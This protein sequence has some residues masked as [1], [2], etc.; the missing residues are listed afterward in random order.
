MK[1]II[2]T[3]IFYVYIHTWENTNYVYIGKGKGLRLN[4]NNRNFFWK[5]IVAKYG[6]PKREIIKNSMSEK[7]AFLFEIE[8]ISKYKKYM[9]VVNMTNGGEG[10]SGLKHSEESRKKIKLSLHNRCC[11]QETREKLRIL[12]TNRVVTQDTRDK[13]SHI[14]AD[15][16]IY[17]FYINGISQEGTTRE[18]AKKYNVSLSRL[19]NLVAGRIKSHMGITFKKELANYTHTDNK[20]YNFMHISGTEENC[21]KEELYKK[22]NLSRNALNAITNSNIRTKTHKGWYLKGINPINKTLDS[23]IY[24]FY[25]KKDN[26]TF[27][28]TRKEFNI[29]HGVSLLSIS[30]I[31]NKYKKSAKG[32][33]TKEDSKSE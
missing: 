31:V 24:T 2:T 29:L 14:K 10:V 16:T 4:S 20:V 28:G 26:I 33:I 22:Y 21:T 7:D 15:K 6:E 17:T 30:S 5:N 25:F 19:R 1:T 3:N 11:K 32:W 12:S 27:V 23:R 18:I 13:I 9:T 8:T